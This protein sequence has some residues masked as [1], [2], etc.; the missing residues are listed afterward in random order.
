MHLVLIPL[1]LALIAQTAVA[2]LTATLLTSEPA[3]PFL[4]LQLQNTNPHTVALLHWHLPFDQR[5]GGA[6]N[7]HVFLDGQR[8]TYIGAKVKY[9]QPS[10]DDYLILIPNEV[11]TVKVALHKL[12][13]MSNPGTYFVK[14]DYYVMDIVNE[15]DLGSVPR[16]QEKFSPSE[17]VTSNTV[18]IALT[19]P[20][21]RP[22]LAP[23]PCSNGERNTIN[24][25]ATHLRNTMITAAQSAINQGSSPSYIE[26][27]GA[28]T[29]GRW[30]TAEE[31]IR[32]IRNN[33]RVGY[34]CDD[35]ANV[36]AYVYPTDT[37]HTIYC[38]SAF[39]SARPIGGFDT[40]AGT[41]LHELSHFNDIGGTNDWVYGTTGARNL[42]RTNPDR[43]VNNAD[44]CEYF[45][46]AQV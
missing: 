18:K 7:F 21:L 41:L 29:D 2:D 37:T 31:V 23:Y 11:A 30:N 12:Y 44:N 39:W 33:N 32:L 15:T 14:F 20:A 28:Y 27:F 24:T 45:G 3:S 43:A 6:N 46:E 5:F 19:V 42:A 17:R 8:V 13:D 1:L 25:A 38:C 22:V 40:Q 35:L 34:E 26:W 10:L 16:L 9:A 36:Y 4:T